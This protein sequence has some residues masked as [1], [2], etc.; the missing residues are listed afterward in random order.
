MPCMRTN[1]YRWVDDEKFLIRIYKKSLLLVLL[2]SALVNM[3]VCAYAKIKLFASVAHIRKA[4][5]Y[6]SLFDFTFAHI[7]MFMHYKYSC[8]PLCD[9]IVVPPQHYSHFR[10]YRSVCVCVCRVLSVEN[11]L[12][13]SCVIHSDT[14]IFREKKSLLEIQCVSMHPFAEKKKK[15]R[16]GK[17][18]SEQINGMAHRADFEYIMRNENTLVYVC[19]SVCAHIEPIL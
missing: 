4:K 3:C 10:C 8:S 5:L 17:S 1:T 13:T 18:R 14:L 7:C 11:W 15:R 19:V 9:C 2:V 16:E 12:E 6:F